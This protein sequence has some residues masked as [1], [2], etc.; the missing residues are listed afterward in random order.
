MCEICDGA[1]YEELFAR[2]ADI[3]RVAG[4]IVITV[5]GARGWSYSIGLLDS[6][7]HPELIAVGGASAPRARMVHGLATKALEGEHFHA[8]DT[9]DL[10]GSR[11]ARVG[12]VHPIHFE[13]ETFAMWQNL[14]DVGAIHRHRPRGVQVLLPGVLL[15]GVA[16]PVLASPSARVG[17]ESHTQP[18]RAARAAATERALTCA[19]ARHGHAAR[20][21][22]LGAAGIYRTRATEPRGTRRA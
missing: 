6:A 12:M 5:A 3:I 1:T 19:S 13:L 4:F 7:D 18:P 14:A 20:P 10:G 16:Q 17:S 9:I 22:R 15:D 8:G 11:I 2:Y 21:T